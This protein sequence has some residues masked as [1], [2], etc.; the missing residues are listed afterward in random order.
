MLTMLWLY[1][2]TNGIIKLAGEDAIIIVYL[3]IFYV[4]IDWA[5]FYA[6]YSRVRRK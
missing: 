5:L 2:T 3:G 1:F 6:L 4:A